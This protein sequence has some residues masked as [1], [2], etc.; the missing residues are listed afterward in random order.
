MFSVLKTISSFFLALVT[1][2]VQEVYRD[3]PPQYSA[4][5]PTGPEQQLE[6]YPG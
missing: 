6:S 2:S 5:V 1:E 3:P 4:Q